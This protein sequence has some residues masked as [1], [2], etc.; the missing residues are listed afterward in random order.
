AL[1]LVLVFV[2]YAAMGS[3]RHVRWLVRGYVAGAVASALVGLAVPPPGQGDAARLS[4]GIGDPN[5]LA[6]VLVPGLAVAVFALPGA[7]GV[8]DRWLLGGGAAVI[9]VA[10]LKTGSRRGPFALAAPR[11]VAPVLGGRLPRPLVRVVLAPAPVLP[12]LLAF[13]AS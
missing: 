3:R 12:A 1:T 7:R 9:A 4:G 11:V 10:V 8:L 13:A 5:E 6:L 2:V